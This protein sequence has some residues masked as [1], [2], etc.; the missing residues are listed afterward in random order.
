MG[1]RRRVVIVG[2]GFAGLEVARGLR[3]EPVDILLLDRTNHHLF[4]PLLYQVATCALSPTDIAMPIRQLFASDSNVEVL[5]AEVTEVDLKARRLVTTVGPVDY[6]FLILAAGARNNYFGNAT[7]PG[8]ALGLKTLDEALKIRRRVLMA[9]ELAEQETD[10][11]RRR[12]LL[13]FVV[14]GGGPTGVELA[15]ALSELSRSMVSNDFRHIHADEISVLL[16]EGGPHILGSFSESMRKSAEKQL[17]K[18]GVHVRCSCQVV[19]MVTGVLTVKMDGKESTI[20]A[21]NVLWAAGVQASELG[22]TLGVPLDR[23]GRVQVDSHLN[24][25]GYEEVF[26]IGDMAQ[27]M[28]PDG[29]PVPGVAPAAMQMGRFV[30]R[31]IEARLQGFSGK[32]FRYVD[33]GNLAT[34]GRSAAVAEVGGLKLQGFVA[35][36]LWL[37]VHILFLVGFRNRALVLFQWAWAYVTLQRGGRVITSAP[38]GFSWP[39]QPRR[40]TKM[41]TAADEPRADEDATDPPGTSPEAASS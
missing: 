36:V 29:R 32:P 3:D 37:L 26:C 39:A 33:K 27:V 19:A 8:V 4:Q 25:P 1:W 24:V 22:K 30:A 16:I 11:A 13:T 17:S 6:H 21:A 7:W 2:G 5:Y 14:I 12:E 20:P 18:L 10:A 31:Q 15:G 34:I 23:S 28:Q 38:E 41:L 40:L 35:W 9:L